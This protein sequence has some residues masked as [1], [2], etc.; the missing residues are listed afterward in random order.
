MLIDLLTAIKEHPNYSPCR[1][2]AVAG[3]N[4]DEGYKRIRNLNDKG[5]LTITKKKYG[6]RLKLTDKAI[7]WLQNIVPLLEEVDIPSRTKKT[8]P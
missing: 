4:Y 7:R 5:M 6:R 3:L 2:L 8:Q 1:A